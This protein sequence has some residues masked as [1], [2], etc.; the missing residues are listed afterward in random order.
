MYDSTSCSY[1]G[2][3]DLKG[4]TTSSASA[5]SIINNHHNNHLHHHHHNNHHTHHHHIIL[6]GAATTPTNPTNGTTLANNNNNS[7]SGNS[8]NNNNNNIKQEN[9][10][11]SY[12]GLSCGSS[13]F[14]QLK[15]SVEKAKQ[16]LVDRGNYL[17]GAFSPPPTRNNSSTVSPNSTLSG[18][19]RCNL[20]F[21]FYSNIG[22]HFHTID[23][24]FYFYFA[25]V[26]NYMVT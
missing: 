12:R 16:A 6:N 15:Q 10:S 9:W 8:N 24:R 11:S 4:I 20:Y 23:F 13:T 3:L 17:A 18:L 25:K 26:I 2:A 5:A 14:Q 19:F 21:N 7:N 1:A 22:Q